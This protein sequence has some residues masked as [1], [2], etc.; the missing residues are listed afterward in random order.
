MSAQTEVR[1]RPII[2]SGE[3]ARAILDGQKSQTRRVVVPQPRDDLLKIA[4]V[5]AMRDGRWGAYSRDLILIGE[6]FAC[7]YGQPG[8]R[9]WV[10]ETWA[11][12]RFHRDWETGYVD[13]WEPA[14]DPRCGTLVYNAGAHGFNDNGDTPEDRGFAWR[15]SIFMPRWASRL[16]LEVTNVRVERVQDISE[17]DAIAEGVETGVWDQALVVR[18]YDE[19][20]AWFQ[21][22]TDDMENYVDLEEIHRASYRTLWDSLNAKRGYGWATNPYVWCLTFRVL[23]PSASARRERDT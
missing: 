12:L 21:M 8:D 9:L 18:K 13:D 16:T 17:V 22:W 19:P 3:S 14:A 4:S 1:E 5:Q 7:P 20:D 23:S 15:P 11:S 2:M 6:P 10:R